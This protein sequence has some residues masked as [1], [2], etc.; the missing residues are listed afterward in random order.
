MMRRLLCAAIV[1]LFGCGGDSDGLPFYRNSALTPEWPGASD[2]NAPAMHRVLAFE[3]RNQHGAVVRDSILDGRVSIVH[4]FFA[5]CG[6]VCPST[7]ANIS[8]L[9]RSLPDSNIV[10]L[11]HS[12]QPEKDTVAALEAYAAMHSIRDPRWQ[13]LTGMPTEMQRLARES[14]FV[15]LNDGRSYGSDRL[16]H[17]ETVVLVDGARRIRGVYNGTLRLD[18][19]RLRDD[20]AVLRA[21]DRS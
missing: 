16:A 12:V 1:V 8:R 10:V 9:L 7:R 4:F 2:H 19:E 5:T 18:M 17:T 21:S 3:L 14:Y 20:I 6:G 15:N 13:L 11:S